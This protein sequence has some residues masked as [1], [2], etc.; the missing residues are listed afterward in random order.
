MCSNVFNSAQ[1]IP[2]LFRA[3]PMAWKEA[4]QGAKKREKAFVLFLLSLVA[5][6]G[7]EPLFKE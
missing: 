6:R 2:I 7:V 4:A 1:E 5:R 3:E